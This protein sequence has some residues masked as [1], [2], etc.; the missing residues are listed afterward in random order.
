MGPQVR[1][2]AGHQLKTA[3][4]HVWTTG[5]RDD[6][7]FPTQGYLINLRHEFATWGCFREPWFLKQQLTAQ[8]HCSLGSGFVLSLSG[9]FGLISPWNGRPVGMLEKFQMGGPC[10]VRAFAPNSLGPRDQQDSLGGMVAGEAGLQLS[11]PLKAP[12]SSNNIFRG[13]FFANAGCLSDHPARG[14]VKELVQSGKSSNLQ[15]NLSVGLGI[16]ARL[17]DAGR[18]E[19]NFGWPLR[20]EPTAEPI[21]GL[22]VGLGVEFL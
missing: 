3:L 15:P 7:I 17:G 14:L 2:Q 4:T 19:A 22:Q 11:F 21:K 8:K 12:D 5:T 16:M 18:L 10:S 9:R 1:R 6:L 20:W 13:H